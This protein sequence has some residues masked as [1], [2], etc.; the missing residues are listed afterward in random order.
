M[1]KLSELT[2]EYYRVGDVAKMLG[3]VNSTVHRW[4]VDGNVSYI[5]LPDSNHRRIA[6]DEV[7]RLLKD[8][9]LFIDNAQSQRK[10]V[11]YA[12]VSTFEQKECGDLDRQI[13]AIKLFVADKEPH[14]LTV[15]T[16]IGSG[17]NDQRKGLQELIDK[18]QKDEVMRIFIERKEC[19]TAFGFHYLEQICQFHH[20]EIIIISDEM[21]H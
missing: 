13:N 9:G 14:V 20:T 8:R 7:I 12:R 4:L 10:D 2:K 1:I 6:K 19:L 16:D 3:V 18:I 21:L 11:I 15:I 17:L 5:T